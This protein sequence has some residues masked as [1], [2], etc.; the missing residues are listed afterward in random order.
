MALTN[1]GVNAPEAVKLWSDVLSREAL[2]ATWI[3]KFVGKDAS[4][5]IQEKSD[6]KKSAGDRLTMILRM[7]LNGDGVLGDSTLEG[8]EEKLATYTDN[9]VIDQLRHAVRSA[10]KMSEQRIPF[11]IREEAKDGL[12]DWIA[13]RLDTAFF[14]QLCGFTA[15]TDLRYTGMNAVLAPTRVYRPN[16][17]TNDQSLTTGDEFTLASIDAAVSAAKLQTPGMRPLRMNGE[18]RWVLF[19][20]PDQ[21]AQMRSNTASG[22]WLDIQKAAT[23]GDGSRNNP[24][25]TGALGMYNGVILHESV[26]I[27]NGVNSSTGAAVTSVRRAVLCGAQAM[28]LGFGRG[29]SVAGSSWDWKEKL[30]DYDNQLGVKA[31][32]I[33]GM[34]ALRYNGADFSK[35]GIHTYTPATTLGA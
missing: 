33:F 18:D 3:G 23:T 34:K 5:L 27:T 12:V 11:S 30:F 15:Q 2:K 32:A 16:A 8:N 28:A 6:F 22:Q 35:I 24:I 19:L 20:H 1:Y 25:F 31:G 9:L 10:G 21:V 17:K 14:N 13:N 26:R 29:N 4:S 7:Q